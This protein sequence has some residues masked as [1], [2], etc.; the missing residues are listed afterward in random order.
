MGCY[1]TAP[2]GAK[3]SR[4]LLGDPLVTHSAPIQSEGAEHMKSIQTLIAAGSLLTALLSAQP[5]KYTVTDLGPTGNPFSQANYVNNNGFVAGLATVAGGAQ[6]ATLWYEGIEGD[7]GAPGLGGPNSGAGG[8]NQFGQA[9]VGAETSSKDPNNENFC[10]YG[11]GLQCVVFLWQNGVITQ[12][13]TLGGVNAGYGSINNRGEVAGFAENSTRD[14]KCPSGVAL[15]G[16][17]PQ[18]LDYEPVIWGPGQGQIRQLSL[19]AGDTVGVAF[20]INDNGQAVGMSGTCANTQLPGLAAA[21]H[22]VLW[23]NGTVTDLGNLGGTANPALLGVGNAA[24]AINNRGQAVGTSALTGNT[25]HHAFLWAWE[26]GMRD[27]GTLPGDAVSAG[28]GINSKGDVIGNSVSPP[29]PPMG[30]P[31][32]F[33]WKNGVM[34]DLNTLIP[35]DSPLQLLTASSINDLGQITGFGVTSG[36][37]IH[38]F[39]ASPSY[40]SSPAAAASVTSAVVTPLTLLTNQPSVVL[41]GSSSTSA[42]GN[43]Q[44]LYEVVSGGLK[45]ALLQT[46]NDPKATVDFVNGPGLY[47]VQLIVTDSSGD[48]SK[49]PVIMLNYEPSGTTSASH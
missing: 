32:P 43:L 27:L 42:S 47:M 19:P 33:L 44:Y 21:P 3:K 1:Y 13:P 20:W 48:T 12:L 41:D 10:G 26:T 18:V 40:L 39:L 37:E 22:A 23:E 38:A 17:G 30:N 9:I 35:A 31:R 29:G 16:S 2:L 25:I 8:V 36:G 5:P 45:P 24:F 49:S 4:Q 15:N 46:P 14:P 34:T 28:L 7:I 6:H 11:T